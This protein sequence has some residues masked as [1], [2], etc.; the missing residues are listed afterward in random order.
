MLDTAAAG[1]GNEA[2]DTAEVDAVE[3][4]VEAGL[5]TGLGSMEGTQSHE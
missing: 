5:T 3:N 2:V 1:V 4:P